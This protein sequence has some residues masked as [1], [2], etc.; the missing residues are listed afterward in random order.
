MVEFMKQTKHTQLE[1]F[2][3]SKFIA[4][5]FCQLFAFMHRR[6]MSF[7]YSV[8]ECSDLKANCSLRNICPINVVNCRRTILLNT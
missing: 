2:S 1:A 7:I 5:V 6:S 8:V 4:A 3:T